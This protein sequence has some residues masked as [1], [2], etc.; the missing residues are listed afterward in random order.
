MATAV[1]GEMIV[2]LMHH[3]SELAAG[4]SIGTITFA[5]SMSFREIY[6]W[7]PLTITTAKTFTSSEVLGLT[8]ATA[9]SNSA[10]SYDLIVRYKE[11]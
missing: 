5:T 2:K 11:K 3:A 8:V 4:T 1:E 10:G 9:T 6:T 7:S